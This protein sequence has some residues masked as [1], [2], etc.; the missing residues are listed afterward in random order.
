MTIYV[1]DNSQTQPR[2]AATIRFEELI[3][4]RLEGWTKD[5]VQVPSPEEV[6]VFELRLRIEDIDEL[7][8]ALNRYLAAKGR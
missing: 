8:D 6:P 4:Y 1:S 3:Y 5:G 2:A 7:R